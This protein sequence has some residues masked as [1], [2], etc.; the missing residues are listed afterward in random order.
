MFRV[1][2]QTTGAALT[3]LLTDQGRVKDAVF[4]PGGHRILTWN[5]EG[6]AQLWTLYVDENTP[7]KH[8]DLQL[9]IQTGTRLND[10]NEVEVLSATAWREKKRL[11]AAD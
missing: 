1:W 10:A 2:D 9:E 5:K 6:S 7:R 4:G 8:L 3:P 11:S